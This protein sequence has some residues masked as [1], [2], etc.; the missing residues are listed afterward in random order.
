M[1]R[2]LMTSVVTVLACGSSLLF[3]AC[4]SDPTGSAS[5]EFARQ[6]VATN[7]TVAAA[8][9]DSAGRDTTLTVVVTGT[10]FDQGSTV[11]FARGGTIDPNLRVNSVGFVSSKELHASLTVAAGATLSTY[12][13]VVT[14]SGGKKGVGSEMFAV[15]LTDANTS[16]TFPLA[17][18]GLGIRSDHLSSNGTSSVYANGV[19]TVSGVLHVS[20]TGDAT[21]Q[22]SA[23]KGKSCG[24]QF[25]VAYPDGTLETLPAFANLAFIE[26]AAG[27]IPT[28]STV[29]RHMNFAPGGTN[30]SSGRCG[31]LYFG[32]GKVGNGIG[33]DSLLVTRVD[34]STWHVYSD[35][36]VYADGL[37]NR[38][39]CGANNQ[40]YAMPVDFTVISSRPE[41]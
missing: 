40:L 22:T 3:L 34:A 31:T 37:H 13:V 9:P 41:P 33:S 6:P 20:V 30:T 19:C 28:G 16:W 21:I 32:V 35:P 14:T 5:P 11:G 15:V 10:G 36:T 29:R 2:N 27:T 12:D 38:A 8:S 24:R 23:T 18:G 1:R 17:D 25:T 7:P 39:L 26:S 4:S